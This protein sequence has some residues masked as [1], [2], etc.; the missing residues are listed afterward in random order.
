[1]NWLAYLESGL[2]LGESSKTLLSPSSSIA[3]LGDMESRLFILSKK[4]RIYTNKKFFRLFWPQ[5]FGH[6]G[7]QNLYFFYGSLK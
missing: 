5:S 7:F 2:E 1:M 6:Y 3:I 4:K